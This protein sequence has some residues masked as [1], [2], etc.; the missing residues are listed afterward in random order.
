MVIFFHPQ[1]KPEQVTVIYPKC[2][3]ISLNQA[4]TKFRLKMV[5]FYEA[6]FYLPNAL[7]WAW[8]FPRGP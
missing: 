2:A 4:E 7:C 8:V 1:Y 5:T 6:L 3:V